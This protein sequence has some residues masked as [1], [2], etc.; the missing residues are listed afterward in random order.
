MWRSTLFLLCAASL[1]AQD[2]SNVRPPVTPVDVQIVRRAREI[3]KSPEVWNQADNRVCPDNAKT[4]S[5]YCALEKATKELSGQFEHR[6]AAMQ[7]TRFVIDDI[8]SGRDYDH[9]LMG[10]NNDPT[11]KFSDIQKVFD[12][13]EA[14]I[15]ARLKGEPEPASKSQPQPAAAAPAP[16]AIVTPTDL[17]V[18]ERARQILNSPEK[19]NRKD[20]QN[21]PGDAKSFSLFCAF[22]MASEQLEGKFNNRGAAIMDARTLIAEG[23]R[24]HK[25]NA[26]LT[27]FNNDPAVQ[28][29]DIQ[30]LFATI[31]ERLS[32][33]LK[34]GK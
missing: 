17:K 2:D 27:D 23:D 19:W 25:Y 16:S 6:G 24:E 11:T 21:C 31:Q 18:L 7:E 20:D 12:L 29:A 13:V 8:A 1:L 33:R 5:L 22:Y 15:Q 32:K 14:R 3:L 26:R 9:R 30:K 28:F 4:F 10:Y 34:S